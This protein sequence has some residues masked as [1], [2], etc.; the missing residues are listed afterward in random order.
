[1]ELG[2][3]TQGLPRVSIGMPVYNG[4]NHIREALDSLL[5]Q[6][7]SD[8]ELI[9][10]DNA[11]TDGTGAICR[12][13]V[14]RDPRIRYVR[15]A[16]NKGAVANFKA[17]LDEAQCKYFMW[18]AHDDEWGCSY[19]REAAAV[20]DRGCF[21]FVFPSF[22]VKS[23]K[24][25]IGKKF[26]EKL[27]KFIE[28]EDRRTR[29]LEFLVLHHNSHKCNIVYSL[30]RTDFLRAAFKV[31]DIGNDGA[32]GAVILGLGRGK[33]LSNALFSK[34]YPML[35]PGALKVLFTRFYKNQSKE[36]ALAK[37]SALNRLRVLF[38]EYLDDIKMI[39]DC[40]HPYTHEK[41]YRICSIDSELNKQGRSNE[42]K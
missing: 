18:A 3:T 39:F 30:F 28:S 6:T 7:F 1:M 23:V 32:L 41:Y 24:L 34:R 10:S 12:E 17:V 42:S 22:S 19:L 38:P 13:Y 11:S 26:D 40:Y 29:V 15:Q 21:D 16:E 5:A 20:L 36:F 35:W 25:K 31:Q 27:F 14:S 8:F 2:N 37:E 4:K 33:L 9:I